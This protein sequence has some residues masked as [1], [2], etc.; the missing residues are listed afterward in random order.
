MAE[1]FVVA[2]VSVEKQKFNL[3]FNREEA[4]KHG[5]T[6]LETLMFVPG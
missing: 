4:I 1:D 6:H 2:L 3:L 5:P